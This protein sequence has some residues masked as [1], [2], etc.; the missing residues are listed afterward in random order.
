MEEGTWDQVGTCITLFLNEDC[1]EYC[2]EY[3][4]REVIKKYSSFMPVEIYLSKADTKETQIIKEDE[5]LQEQ[6]KKEPVKAVESLLGI[7]LP[8]DMIEKVVDGVKAKIKL[9]QASDALG[10]LKKLF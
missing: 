1:L 2:N 8:D 9:D 6:F 10:M 5:K 3:K 4:A 7:D